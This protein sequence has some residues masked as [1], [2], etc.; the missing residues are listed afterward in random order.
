[1]K[2]LPEPN[3]TKHIEASNISEE[4]WQNP[5]VLLQGDIPSLGHSNYLKATIIH[6][7]I[8]KT[9][10]SST[11]VV[12]SNFDPTKVCSGE[13]LDQ[14]SGSFLKKKIIEKQQAI[15]YGQLEAIGDF[16][17]S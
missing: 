13:S 2:Q 10:S 8:Q 15:R 1:M 3:I 6:R 9:P 14:V 16:N 7:T 4:N 17:A 11:K 12:S 5:L